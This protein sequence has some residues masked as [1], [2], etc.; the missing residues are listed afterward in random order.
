MRR[1]ANFIYF[2]IGILL[3]VD[4]RLLV[5]KQLKLIKRNTDDICSSK[6]TPSF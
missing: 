2:N 5:S 1:G 3:T 6:V 4:A